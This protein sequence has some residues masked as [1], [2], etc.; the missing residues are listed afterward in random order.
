VTAEII[1]REEEL[2]SIQAFLERIEDGP[3]ALVLSGEAGIGKTIL[4]ERGVGEAEGRSRGVLS[5]RSVEAEASL[6]FT[7]LSD[8]LAPVFDDVA[9]SLAPLRR[10]ALEVALLLA[11]PGEEAPDPRA[12]GLALLD[13]LRAL[14]EQGPV[15]VALDDV[16]WLDS[17]S[18]G[19]LQIALRRLRDERV[20]LAATVRR[21]PD[22]AASLE[23]ERAFPEE[24]LTRLV[25]GPLS[26]GG[27]HRLLKE[28]LGLELT[29]P[30]LVRVHEASAGNPF[31]AL[32]LGR[33]LV[34]TNTRPEAG[35]TLPVPESLHELL[36]GRLAR[37]PTETGDVVLFAAALARPTIELVAAAH[38]D[39]EGVVEAL[40]TAARE[41][42]VELDDSR[43]RFAHPLLASICYEQAPPWKRRA[44]HGALARTV[45]DAEE[46]ARHL[47]LSVD[48]PDAAVAAELDI[49]AL[50]AAARGAPAAA[51]GL[52]ELAAELTPTTDPVLVR[53]RRLQAATFLR[54]AGDLERAATMLEQLLTEVPSGV[55]R[56]DVLF[57]LALTF[58]PGVPAMIELCD[59]ALVE[60]AG[61]DARS[62]RV[63]AFRSIVHLNAANVPAALADARAALEKAE[64]TGDPTLL[65]VS[66]A[67]VG[68]A[69]T[70][71]AEITPGLLERGAE[72]EERFGLVLEYSDSPRVF[73]ARLLTRLGEID[74]ARAILEEREAKAA[75]R[76]DEITRAVV[77]WYLSIVE[78]TA[79]RWQ[80]ALE[81]AAAAHELAVQTQHPSARRWVGSTKAL[82]EMDL[83]LIDEA[84]ASIEVGLAFSSGSSNEAF[85]ILQLGLL[86]R[87][88]LLLGN[89]EEAGR[90]LR[91]L[92]ERLLAGGMNDPIV[93]VWADAIETLIALGE[94]EQARAYL[95]PYELHA[96][97]LSSPL[98]MEG[99]LRCR[100]L[101][102][103]ADGDLEAAFAAFESALSEQPEPAWPFERARTLLCLGI[104]R[105]QAQQK[106]A[107]R[108]ALE[109]ALATFEELG[110]RLWAEK[111]RAELRRISGRA[112]ASDELTETE[113]RV[114]ELAAQ[115]HTNREIAAELFMGMSTVEAHLSRVYR[116]L[117]VR[118]AELATQLAMAGDEAVKAKDGASQ[119]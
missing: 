39:R 73:L 18:A 40:D 86:G 119:T 7:G 105:R 72:L 106:R 26:V 80:R 76:G 83:G 34:R 3:G 111:A 13:A 15:L 92:P 6:S 48:G 68:Q 1:G 91:D 81:Q 29:R 63:L 31:F 99:V 53:Q 47:A 58:G 69:E 84:R 33:E 94:L 28:R 70:W 2:A 113:R 100:G 117:G 114:A 85:T 110:A 89:L 71:A 79:G 41:G 65:A 78:W 12:I 57:A 107:A 45:A 74:R 109:Q 56:A 30:E 5:H 17:S 51:A 38:G 21:T 60:A 42:V 52:C 27:L 97:R 36:D 88:E 95:E 11:E 82:I 102:A 20:G 59:E 67:H 50:H 75:A 96:R 10:R 104:V 66:I 46:R 61:D 90:H 8:L 64:A 115:G 37:L 54:I 25:L 77:M 22:V 87:L 19:V 49:A 116:K 16:Q 112:P 93:L 43:L 62:A 23:L 44:I 14:A 24:R 4:W 55:E 98:A 108:E 9:P 101:L 118:R 35:R 32:E 103:A